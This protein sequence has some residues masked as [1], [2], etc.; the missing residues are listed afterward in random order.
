[1]TALLMTKPLPPVFAVHGVEEQWFLI[2]PRQHGCGSIIIRR[3]L[4][5]CESSSP[6]P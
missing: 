1:M 6:K 2:A 4:V 5:H 3:A